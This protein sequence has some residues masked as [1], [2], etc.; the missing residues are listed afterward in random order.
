MAQTTGQPQPIPFHLADLWGLGDHG[1]RD[2]V[3]SGTAAP[4][5]TDCHHRAG[6]DRSHPVLTWAGG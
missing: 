3:V 6:T 1:S 2:V 4:S 5:G